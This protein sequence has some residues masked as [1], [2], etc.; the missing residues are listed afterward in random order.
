MRS[1]SLALLE[2]GRSEEAL[3]VIRRA[4]ELDRN[5]EKLSRLLGDILLDLDRP[6]E[7]ILAYKAATN[8]EYLNQLYRDNVLRTLEDCKKEGCNMLTLRELL[9]PMIPYR[10]L[11]TSLK[12]Y[13]YHS[14]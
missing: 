7:A 3:P 1:R 8:L 11:Q 6:D 5:E 2:A 13:Q 14:S 10:F 9:N 4:I 12:I